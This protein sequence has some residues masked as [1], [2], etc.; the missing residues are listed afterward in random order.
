MDRFRVRNS[1]ISLFSLVCC[2]REG[3]NDSRIAVTCMVCVKLK[4]GLNDV[5]MGL[6][7]IGVSNLK[8]PL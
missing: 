2:H 7:V 6:I 8:N 5:V 4:N 3:G 1:Y